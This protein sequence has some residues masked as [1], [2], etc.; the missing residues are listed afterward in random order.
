MTEEIYQN[1]G[2]IKW[3]LHATYNVLQDLLFIYTAQILFIV[4]DPRWQE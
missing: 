3:T 2:W 1:F 4:D